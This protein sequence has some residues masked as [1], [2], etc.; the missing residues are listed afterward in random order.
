MEWGQGTNT[1]NQRWEEI[2]EG[3]FV[4]RRV[5]DGITTLTVQTKGNVVRKNDKNNAIKLCQ[6]GEGLTANSDFWGEVAS[7]NLVS[8]S[9]NQ[10]VVDILHAVKISGAANPVQKF[11]NIP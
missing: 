2:G 1:T 5:K 11:F 6:Q 8:V 9:G 3:T 4:S 10:A 7:G